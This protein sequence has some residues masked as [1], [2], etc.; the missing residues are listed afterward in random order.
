VRRQ[1]A[2]ALKFRKVKVW[3]PYYYFSFVYGFQIHL[4]SIVC[5]HVPTAQF[6]RLFT[7][8]IIFFC[9]VGFLCF[10]FWAHII[11][12]S[13]ICLCT[14]SACKLAGDWPDSRRGSGRWF[15]HLSAANL[16][17]PNDNNVETGGP[18]PR[19][20]HLHRGDALA[21]NSTVTTR[22]LRDWTDMTK[23][24]DFGVELRYRFGP[25]LHVVSEY[26][27]PLTLFISNFVILITV[28]LYFLMIYAGG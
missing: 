13:L 17:E 10:H 28:V 25:A 22:I 6:A 11:I 4:Q 7:G 3:L 9:F 12:H 14:F 5:Q 1:R 26:V 16:L 19:W 8:K 15:L 2:R 24:G 27:S 18:D 23:H 20:M 21:G